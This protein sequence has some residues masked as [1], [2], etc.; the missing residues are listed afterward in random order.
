MLEEKFVCPFCGFESNG[1][2]LCPS[3]DESLQKVCYCGSGKFSADCCN[4][5]SAE[6]TKAEEMIKAEVA[7]EALQELATKEEEEIKEEEELAKVKEIDEE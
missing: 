1:A 5:N 6:D 3:C 7:G 4:S 2:G